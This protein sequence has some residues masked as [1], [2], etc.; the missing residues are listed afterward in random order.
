MKEECLICRQPL[1]YLEEDVLMECAVCH[2]KESSKTR[3]I[4]GHYV[5]SE[6]HNSGDGQYNRADVC[7]NTAKILLR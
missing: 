1:E 3:C 4:Q 5:C 2:K 7:M 6:C